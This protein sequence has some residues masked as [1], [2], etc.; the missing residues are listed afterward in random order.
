M[1]TSR[2][3]LTWLTGATIKKLE[4]HAPCEWTFIPSVGG[5]LKAFA[6]WRVVEQSAVVVSSNELISLDDP[7]EKGVYATYELSAL[8]GQVVVSAEVRDDA[9][10]LVVT[11][12]SGARLEFLSL[13]SESE[14]WSVTSPDGFHVL[15]YPRG[16]IAT[17][18]G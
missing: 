9:R 14:S 7:L 11:F 4:F 5:V 3:H 13:Y 10:D 6:Q 8:A 15:G 18:N 17:W 1:G 16:E 12:G 2:E